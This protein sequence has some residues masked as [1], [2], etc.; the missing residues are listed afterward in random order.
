MGQVGTL[1]RLSAGAMAVAAVT[2]LALLG[3]SLAGAAKVRAD[4]PGGASNT[5]QDCPSPAGS[6]GWKYQL[7]LI[8][9]RRRCDSDGTSR[10]T[11]NE[12]TRATRRST[13]ARTSASRLIV[14]GGRRDEPVHVRP[15]VT[16]RHRITSANPDGRGGSSA[17]STSATTPSTPTGSLTVIKKVTNDDGGNAESDDWTMN[18]AGP[19]ASSFPGAD[20]PGTTKTVNTGSYT[21]TESGGPS[22]YTLTYSG[23]C[24]ANG[25]VTVGANDTKTCTLTNDDN[26]RP[27]PAKGKIIVEKQLLPDGYKP[28]QGGFDF[29]GAITAKLGDGESA[30]LDVDAGTYSITESLAGR[31]SWD[32]ISIVCSDQDS[33]G[34]LATLTATYKVDAGETVKCT[35]TNQ[36]RSLIIVKKVTNPTGLAGDFDFT[37]SYDADGFTLSDG[38]QNVSPELLAGNYSVS[39][40]TPDGWTSEGS[41]TNGDDPSSIDLPASTVVT[42]TFVNTPTDDEHGTII[43]KKVTDPATDET[44]FDF[45]LGELEFA[46]AGGEQETVDELEPGTYAVSE[47]TREGW[48]LTS[49]TCSDQSDPD[50]IELSAGETV[51]CTFTNTKRGTIIVEKQTSPDATQGSFSF[52]GDA[53]GTIGDG[54]QI[55]VS[56]LKPGTYFSTEGAAAGWLLTAIECD[57]E[58]S[59]GNLGTRTATFQLDAG[60]TVRCVFTNAKQTVGK[61]SIDVQKSASPTSLKEPGGPVEFSVRITNTSDVNVSITNVMDDKFGDLD[62][63]G[64]NGCFDVPVNLAPGQSRGMPVHASDHGIGRNRARQRRVRG[65]DGRVRQSAQG[66]RRRAGHDHAEADRPRDRQDRDVADAAQRHRQ[67]LADGDEQGAGHGDERRASET[68]R[69]RGSP[70]SRRA[71]RRAHAHSH[72]RSSSAISGRSPQVRR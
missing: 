45:T 32:L 33:S 64:G 36:K 67:L 37:A 26:D 10:S 30:S 17:I 6:T 24:N 9:Q 39:E 49:A 7:E 44:D 16:S 55:V 15:A 58:E 12:T 53:A 52:T 19:S 61:G 65:R 51:T 1:K 43:V 50:E 5:A 23:D 29:S 34:D 62:D 69:L 22:G 38:E 18:V 48:D 54:Q 3:S 71:R 35:F 59:S 68:R 41:C 21:V 2:L 60:E 31:P 13:G 47:R 8:R 56:D 42:C 40:K 72:R 4:P 28:P 70:T 57:D 11:I 27:P 20:T 63:S 46:L 14:K 66:L 25:S